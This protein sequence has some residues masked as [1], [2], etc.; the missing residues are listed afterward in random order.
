MSTFMQYA[1]LA[2]SEALEDAGWCP[3]GDQ[4]REMTGVCLGS[5][6]GSLEVQ[7]QTSVDLYRAVS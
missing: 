2:S 1:M 7:Y 6:I 4:Q 3:K 5:G